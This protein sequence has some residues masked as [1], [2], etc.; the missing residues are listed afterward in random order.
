VDDILTKLDSSVEFIDPANT[1]IEYSA[2]EGLEEQNLSRAEPYHPKSL[3][4][5]LIVSATEQGAVGAS[6]E[7]RS[8]SNR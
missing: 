2:M 6:A 7:I 1:Q 4:K 3:I 5:I 8:T